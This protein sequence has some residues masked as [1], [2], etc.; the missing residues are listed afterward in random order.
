M[1][2]HAVSKILGV[3][4]EFLF[5]N[6]GVEKGENTYCEQP[7]QLMKVLWQRQNAHCA[8]TNLLVFGKCQTMIV[9]LV[10]LHNSPNAQLNQDLIRLLLSSVC[11]FMNNI[12][13]LC[14]GLPAI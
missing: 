11:Q 9:E 12:N 2:M 1:E 8:R 3:W 5:L 6:P 4:S 13:D 14:C 10:N 7:R